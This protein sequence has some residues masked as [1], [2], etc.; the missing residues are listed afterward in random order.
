MSTEIVPIE[1]EGKGIDVKVQSGSGGAVYG[2]GLI[3]AWVYYFSRATTFQEGL[4]GFFKGLVW[5]AIL[6]YKIYLLLDK[7]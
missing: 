4:V 7:E 6:V 2:L 3:G 1:K 5:P